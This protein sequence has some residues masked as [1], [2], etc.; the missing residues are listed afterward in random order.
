[1]LTKQEKEAVIKATRFN[2]DVI[3]GMNKARGPDMCLAEFRGVKFSLDP[4]GCMVPDNGEAAHQAT[5][6]LAESFGLQAGNCG[7]DFCNMFCSTD[8][9]SYMHILRHEGKR[10]FERWDSV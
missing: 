8:Y 6:D 1:M 2:G 9:M 5:L 3:W 10:I 7:G 4:R